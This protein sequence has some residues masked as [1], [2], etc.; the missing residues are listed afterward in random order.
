MTDISTP[1]YLLDRARRRL[2]PTVGNLP[3]M[4]VLEAGLRNHEWK[5]IMLAEPPPGSGL[6]PVMGDSGCRSSGTHRD[7][8][9]AVPT[10]YSICI[11]PRAP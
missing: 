4:G 10:T 6:K 3:G 1:R 9:V 11:R 2:L 8:S 7:C 5:Q